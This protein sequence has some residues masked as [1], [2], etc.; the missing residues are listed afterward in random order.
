MYVRMCVCVSCFVLFLLLLF[1]CLFFV[2]F[3]LLVVGGGGGGCQEHRFP[4]A[5]DSLT[6]ARM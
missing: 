6:C 5:A 4:V 2:R 1:V 3:A